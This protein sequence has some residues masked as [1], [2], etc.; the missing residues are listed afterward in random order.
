[1]YLKSLTVRGFKSFASATV[2]EF[3]PGLNVL[4][5]PNGSGKSNVVDAL[6][7]VMGAQG[8]KQLRGGAMKDVI[9]AGGGSRGALGRAKVE[10]VIDNEDGAL[11]LPHAEIRLS[12]TM[13]SA[14]G[15]EY[16]INGE[17]ARLAD[18][19][20]LLADAGVGREPY[21]LVGQGQVDKI[22]HGT[23]DGRRERAGRKSG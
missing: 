5:G 10:L 16:E 13:F 9:F 11:P 7:W 6:A 4:V 14:G 1:M 18:V 20:D 21:T 23:A 22:L 3:E 15:S 19:Q 2:F 8:A 17:P 12:R